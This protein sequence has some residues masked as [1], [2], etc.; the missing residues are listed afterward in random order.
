MLRKSQE[1]QRES[2]AVFDRAREDMAFIGRYWCKLVGWAFGVGLA[3]GLSARGGALTEFPVGQR[4]L[5][6]VGLLVSCNRAA[7]PRSSVSLRQLPVGSNMRSRSVGVSGGA[8]HKTTCCGDRLGA[9][10]LR[11]ARRASAGAVVVGEAVALGPR[12]R[13]GPREDPCGPRRGEG[14]P[15]AGAARRLEQLER[16]WAKLITGRGRERWRE[17]AVGQMAGGRSERWL[18]TSDGESLDLWPMSPEHRASQNCHGRDYAQNRGAR[19]SPE[20]TFV[21]RD[22]R[23]KQAR[24]PEVPRGR[25]ARHVSPRTLGAPELQ[26]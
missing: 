9:E 11:S 6:M 2:S 13:G 3:L 26:D 24:L 10:R 1:A 21:A 17:G 12:A 4:L 20:Q 22:L 15:D 23:R 5:C 19:K 8:G 14:G 7:G 25:D 16:A 18:P